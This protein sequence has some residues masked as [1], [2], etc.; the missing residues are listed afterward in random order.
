MKKYIYL[1]ALLAASAFFTGCDLDEEPMAEASVDMVFSSENG[2]LT[3]S[4]SFYNVL[5]ERGSASH[6]NETLDYGPKNNLSGMEVGAYT[7]NSST[8]WD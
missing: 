8:S 1:S 2:L 3:Y 4:Y 5:P 6:R 7:V